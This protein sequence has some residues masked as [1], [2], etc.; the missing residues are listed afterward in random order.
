MAARLVSQGPCK[1]CGRLMSRW[2]MARHLQTCPERL[3]A[4]EKANQRPGHG[5]SLYHLQ[6][7]DLYG[8][9]YW[10]HLEMRGPASLEELD[11]Y[12]RRIWLEC[13][14]HLSAFFVGK[15]RMREEVD[16]ETR[17]DRV[18]SPGLILTHVYD[19]G[20]SSKTLIKVVGVRQGKALTQHPIYLMAR[21]APFEMS[22]VE[23]DQPARWM[24]SE[25]FFHD[26]PMLFCDEHA[27]THHYEERLYRW[28]NSPRVG[29]CGYRGPA[30]PPY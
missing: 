29:M 14:A 17:A 11:F 6:V 30:E 28:V 9:N 7:Q 23:C 20:T 21:N 24:C 13:C 10:L 3:S 8:G 12:L 4:I 22:C 26:M 15:G 27:Y 2:G 16:M 1:F 19:F 25:C 18:F 5:E